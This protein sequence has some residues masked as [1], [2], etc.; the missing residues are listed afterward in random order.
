MLG[1]GCERRS[2]SA[3][4]MDMKPREVNW[5]AGGFAAGFLLCY[6]LIGAFRARPSGPALLTKATPTPVAWRPALA[7]VTNIQLPELHIVL[8]DRWEHVPGTL[9]DPRPPGYSLDLIDT[10]YQPP[11]LP[12]KP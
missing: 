1:V 10:H 12:E 4:Q 3:C 6:V 7:V 11:P 5:A 9:S 2:R 8:P